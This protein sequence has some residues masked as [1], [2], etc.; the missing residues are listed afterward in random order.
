MVG[1]GLLAYAAWRFV[2]ASID[3]EDEG[4]DTSAVAKRVSYVASGLVYVGL[5]ISA[6]QIVLGQNSSGGG[7]QDWTARVLELS[8][9]RWLVGLLGFAIIVAGIYQLKEAITAGF[10]DKFALSNMDSSQTTW[11]VRAGRVGHGARSVVYGIIGWFLIRAAI[12]HS[13]SQTG[14]LGEALSTLEQ[15]PYGRWLLGFAGLGLFCYGIYCLVLGR[16]HK[17]AS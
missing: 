8:F 2:Q 4:E 3:P 11:A 6:V 13:A 17:A 7:A 15:Q 9:G 12:T 1:I 10:K 5:A 14:G 16:Y